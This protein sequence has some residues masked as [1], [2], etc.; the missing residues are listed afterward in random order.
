M[1]SIQREPVVAGTF[2]SSYSDELIA[3]LKYCYDKAEGNPSDNIAALVVPHA[4]YSYSGVVA[5]SAYTQINR[6]AEY[7]NIFI[8]GSSHHV[9]FN[10]ASVY[11]KG[12][13]KTPLGVAPVNLQLANDLIDSSKCFVFNREAHSEEH[14][15]EVQLP[16]LQYRIKHLNQIVP[17]IIGAKNYGTC[18]TVA[19][20]L[21]PYFNGENLFI[22]STD[23]SHYPTDEAARIIDAQ[24][25]NAICQNDSKRLIDHLNKNNNSTIPNMLT[26]LCGW[27]SVLTLLYLTEGKSQYRYRRIKYMNSSESMHRQKERVVGYQSILIED[28]ERKWGFVS[29]KNKKALLKTAK[30]AIQRQ[31]GFNKEK[32]TLK[33]MDDLDQ[34][35]GA[36]VSIYVEGKLRGCV[37]QFSSEKGLP[38]LVESLATASAFNDER[39]PPVSAREIK[40]M[41]VE[42]SILTPM[43]KIY[44]IEDIQLG[45]HGVH[46]E[47]DGKK[48]TFLPQ[49]ATKTGWNLIELLGHLARDKA[50]IGWD[51]W[52]KAD[53]Y[54]FEA[55]VF[56][57]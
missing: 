29:H 19:E 41:R 10:G 6:E 21:R 46:L 53:L 26:S 25:V 45:K 2:Y 15:I 14:S 35:R 55:I 54:V 12:H 34:F 40:N 11:N 3:Q 39:F 57:N 36:F 22:F 50:H 17:I 33:N 51:G 47:K 43:R 1:L 52:R 56:S 44:S 49:V 31:L 16:F 48:G 7:K 13:Y 37:G 20:A 9:A 32:P 28:I 5:A 18:K 8:I 38:A 24:T 30:N 27:S 23:L 42:I 4:G